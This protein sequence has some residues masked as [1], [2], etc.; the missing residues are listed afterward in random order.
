M[1]IYAEQPV[2]CEEHDIADA[3]DCVMLPAL[4]LEAASYLEIVLHDVTTRSEMR[5]SAN[6]KSV[7]SSLRELIYSRLPLQMQLERAR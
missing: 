6:S 4:S 2:L 1:L 5:I 7:L 3:P